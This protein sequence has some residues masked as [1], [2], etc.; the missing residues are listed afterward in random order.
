MKVN[1]DEIC[2]MTRCESDSVEYQFLYLPKSTSA[3][4]FTQIP[5]S[6][7]IREAWAAVKSAAA[8]HKRDL[9]VFESSPWAVFGISSPIIQAR[10]ISGATKAIVAGILEC[11]PA[12]GVS[13]LE[14]YRS[15]LK[16]ETAD[17][18]W[19][20]EAM[21]RDPIPHFY[22]QH[23]SESSV[24]WVDTR[25]GTSTWA[26]PHYLKYSHMLS[27]AREV[28]PRNEPKALA[29]FQLE[30][31]YEKLQPPLLSIE[32]IREFA[33][34]YQVTLTKEPFLTE[35]L[36]AAMRFL[37]HSLSIQ[38]FQEFQLRIDRKRRD[39]ADLVRNHSLRS[40]EERG[41]TN[42]I[43]CEKEKA[44]IHCS[45][46]ED[47]FCHE[48]FKKIHSTGGRKY[49]H[50]HSVVEIKPCDD[51]EERASVF[52]CMQCLDSFCEKCFSRIH[53]RG[54]RRNHIPVILHRG[55]NFSSFVTGNV[56]IERSQ[57]VW[58]SLEGDES[59][60]PIYVNLESNESRRDLPL[61]VINTF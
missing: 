58:I 60:R 34:I 10:I 36:K 27:K 15:Y 40:S 46:C 1:D 11:D 21:M 35:T 45:N 3:V 37:Q 14:Q 25:T 61:S 52:H 29:C 19:V 23:V 41:T 32:N 12:I 59:G 26:H 9:K 38:T 57:S 33:R 13:T 49:R 48:C 54:G 28:K 16:F 2:F 6:S 17:P 42:C 53:A 7:D 55:G 30:C 50:L 22:S 24:Y 39:Y 8:A 47:L 18:V 31:M 20:A 4:D 5:W 43:E 44:T 51:C 56:D